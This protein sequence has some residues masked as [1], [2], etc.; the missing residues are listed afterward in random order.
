MIKDIQRKC[1]TQNTLSFILFRSQSMNFSFAHLTNCFSSSWMTFFFSFV[2]FFNLANFMKKEQIINWKYGHK[3]IT[4]FTV[5]VFI[6]IV[7][8][9]TI[10][11]ATNLC[12]SRHNFCLC[13]HFWF[14]HFIFRCRHHFMIVIDGKSKSTMALF[15]FFYTWMAYVHFRCMSSADGCCTMAIASKFD[16]MEFILYCALFDL[17][18]K[19][20]HKKMSSSEKL[21]IWSIYTAFTTIATPSLGSKNYFIATPCGFSFSTRFFLVRP[22]QKIWRIQS[23]KNIPSSKFC[24][25]NSQVLRSQKNTWNIQFN[26]M[27]VT[28]KN[29]LIQLKSGSV[30]GVSSK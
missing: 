15:T 21:L 14:H 4:F 1:S 27:C 19:I 30:G 13:E 22:N 29:H 16:R 23:K 25:K 12:W 6:P 17:A 9:G 24:S 18:T 26:F 2:F 5:Q 7:V 8:V 11:N 10:A 20:A 28:I 3:H